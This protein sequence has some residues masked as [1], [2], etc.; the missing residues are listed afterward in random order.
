MTVDAF[1]TCLRVSGD[2]CKNT[3][4]CISCDVKNSLESMGHYELLAVNGY[5]LHPIHTH[6]HGDR[7]VVCGMLGWENKKTLGT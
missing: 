5:H 2:H 3:L 7:N 6:Q 4:L 1:C